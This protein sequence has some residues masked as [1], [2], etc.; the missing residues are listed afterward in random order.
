MGTFHLSELAGQI[1]HFTNGMYQIYL[2]K[3]CSLFTT[4]WNSFKIVH[5]IFRMCHFEEFQESVLQIGMDRLRSGRQA[6]TNG[7]HPYS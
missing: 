6:L 2:N 7:K 4:S 1:D 5:V 3:T